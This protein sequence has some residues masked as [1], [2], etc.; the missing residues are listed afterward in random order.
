MAEIIEK[1]GPDWKIA[2]LYEKAW[3]IVKKNKVLWIFGAATAG[4][5]SNFN[6][7]NFRSSD[8]DSLQKIF[9]PGNSQPDSNQ[10]TQ[11]L[12]TAT[13]NQSFDN[14]LSLFSTIPPYVYAILA[15][16]I[17]LAL[18]AWIFFGVLKGAWGEGLLIAGSQAGAEGKKVTI[19]ESSETVLPHLRPLIWLKVV[20]ALVVFLG[21]FGVFGLLGIGMALGPTP[22]KIVVGIVMIVAFLALL[23]VFIYL[24]LSQIW[25]QRKVIFE[26]M[27]GKEALFQSYRISRKKNGAMILLGLVNAILGFMAVLIP[28]GIVFLLGYLFFKIGV[29]ENGDLI[30]VLVVL[31]APL[32]LAS[33]VGLMLIGGILNAFK[34]AVWTLA[35]NKIK[36]KYEGK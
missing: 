26:N 30:P 23:W 9:Q 20:P 35:Y 28:L 29:F 19:Q 1:Q 11:V 2:E 14:F 5:A 16:E 8:T 17:A 32:L 21:A 4:L 34:A 12:G 24:T 18:I 6:T 22:V 3:E 25:A 33:V 31:A 15:V 27:E 7:S 13:N 36:G 10:L